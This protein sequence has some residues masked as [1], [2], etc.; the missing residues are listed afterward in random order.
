MLDG[1]LILLLVRLLIRLPWQRLGSMDSLP[2]MCPCPVLVLCLCLCLSVL[3]SRR[4]LLQKPSS[5]FPK[6][7]EAADS[8]SSPRRIKVFIAKVVELTK[9]DR[10]LSC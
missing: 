10:P 8:L 5:F 4:H 6:D 7:G 2:L 3:W 9:F 1:E